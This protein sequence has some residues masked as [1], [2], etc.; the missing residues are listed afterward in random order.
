MKKYDNI[1]GFPGYYISKRGLLWSRY[2][3]GILSNV[4]IK[5]KFYLSS[6]NGRYKTSIVHE[7][8]GKIKMNRYRLVALA[9]IPNPKGDP[10]VCHKD[11]NPTN[12]YY[13]NLYW[14]THK[15]NMHQ[16]IRDGRWYTPFN[17][18]DNPNKNKR[19]WKLN[20]SITESQ[21]RSVIK[22]REWGLTNK[23]IIDR[24]KIKMSSSGIS[25]IWKNYLKGYYDSVLNYK[26]I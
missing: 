11:N 15:E 18:E 20:T 17:T 22:M 7:T 16:M 5:K 13:K 14:G 2:S 19:G 4:W 21:F 8:L 6:T 3:K 24:L 25:R 12:D 10:E 26:D 1:P 23:V 9:Y